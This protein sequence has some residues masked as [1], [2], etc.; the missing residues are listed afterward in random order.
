MDAG[1]IL[2]LGAA[3]LAFGSLGLFI[4][5]AS[6]H[7]L[8]GLGWLGAAF[9]FG[10]AG[11]I[12]LTLR[13]MPAVVTVL[14]SDI[15]VLLGFVMLHVAVM[16]LMTQRHLVPW[17]SFGLLTAMVAFDMLRLNGQVS[18]QARMAVVSL[19][20]A[21]QCTMSARLLWRAARR[22]ERGPALFCSLILSFF[23]GFNLL[24]SAVC[25]SGL[26]G[27]W[28]WTG[29]VITGGYALYIAIALG[30]AFGFFW[31]S[32]TQLSLQL[33]TMAGTDPLT[34]LYNRRTFQHACEQELQLARRKERPFSILMVD[35]DHFKSI[36]DRYG[37]HVGDSALIAAVQAMQDSIRGSDVLA[38]WGGEEFAALLPNA[39]IE[40][41]HVVAER[42]RA[43]V[44]R[45]ELSMSAAAGLNAPDVVRMTVSIGL[46]TCE[47]PDDILAVMTRAD[48]N[49]YLAKDSGR[50]R[51][52]SSIPP[53][54]LPGLHQ[55]PVQGQVAQL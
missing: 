24:R 3:I 53:E 29:L 30:L 38:R 15:C 18:T 42:L 51:V 5:R 35:L 11:A 6:N 10:F 34:R 36:N 44:E 33:E 8:R 31:M 43:N 4:V 22:N 32:T 27:H 2:R 19:L 49:L 16:E 12:T 14:G 41:A 21:V 50:N 47:P 17:T 26:L 40:A 25:A 55:V 52:L 48:Q 54:I 39:N 7:R 9:A 46:A 28:Y 13:G 20:V 45:V 23:A 37:H 1:T